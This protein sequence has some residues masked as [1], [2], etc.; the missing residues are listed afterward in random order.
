M[1]E[2]RAFLTV[3]DYGMGGVWQWIRAASPEQ[4]RAEYP[5]LI[6][7]EELPEWWTD[8]RHPVREV[9]LDDTEDEFLASLR[10]HRSDP[11]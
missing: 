4:I 8:D 11:D 2:P 1:T 5:E 3:Y 7:V 10:E 6:V 9:D